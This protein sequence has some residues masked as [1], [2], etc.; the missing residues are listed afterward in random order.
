MRSW[1][2]LGAQWPWRPKGPSRAPRKKTG[3]QT[4]ISPRDASPRGVP[5]IH[6]IS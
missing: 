6:K 2:G 1:T 5:W 4:R 3:K